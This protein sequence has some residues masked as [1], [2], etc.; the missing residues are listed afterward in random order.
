MA[1]ANS[2]PKQLAEQSRK[3]LCYTVFATLN[4]LEIHASPVNYELMYE[5]ISGSNPELRE[6]FARLTKPIAEEELDALARAYLPHH[7][8]KSLVDESTNR[9]QSELSTLKE[10]LQSGQNS[11]S[12][13]SSLL[14]QATGKIS[15]IDPRDTK[16]IQSHLQ[17]IR[18]LTEVQQSKSTQML[19]SVS[20]Q[21][22]AVAAIA[23]DVEEFERTKFTHL[24]TNLANR[25][26]FNKKLAELYG[27]ERYPEGAS[28]ILCN[29]LALEPFEARELVK[30]KEA[31][32]ERLGLV[33]SQTI[34]TTDF[35]AWLDRP[36]IG[37]LVWTSAE[38]EIQKVSDQLKKSCQ[39]AFD[40]RQRRMPVVL[41]RFGCSTTFDAGTASELVGHAEKA[42]Q[43]ATETASDRVMFF[44]GSEA[45]GTRKDW[46]LYR[47]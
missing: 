10:S 46:M 35:A 3:E 5:I 20:T 21:I 6:K 31:I 27:G 40:N 7:F 34:Q 41:A 23:S 32:L 15:S 9:I 11:L 38:A 25:R 43:T 16:S 47:K 13:Y 18:Q 17:T 28:L 26:G 33:V 42:L 14:G 12:S 1:I 37:I 39:S 36:Q 2:S 24:A 19:E 8:G 4:R 45:G 22:S 29:L 30:L 44:A